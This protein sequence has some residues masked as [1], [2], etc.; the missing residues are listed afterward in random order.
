MQASDMVKEVGEAY[1][2][3]FE[4]YFLPHAPLQ[5]PLANNFANANKSE[6][7]KL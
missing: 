1:Q 7:P 4:T 6:S 5:L 2:Y 3:L